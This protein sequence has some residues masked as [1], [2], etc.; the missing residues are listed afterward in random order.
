MKY[1]NRIRHDIDRDFNEEFINMYE[2]RYEFI[3]DDDYVNYICRNFREIKFENI[4]FEN[5]N[6]KTQKYS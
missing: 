3:P 2:C 4:K 1:Y 6:K 5:L